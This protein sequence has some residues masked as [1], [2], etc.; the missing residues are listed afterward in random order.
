MITPCM[1]TLMDLLSEV[2]R[3]VRLTG[4]IHLRG[5]FTEPWAFLSTPP[6]LLAARYNLPEGEVTQFDV[7]VEG[8]CWVSAGKLAPVRMETGDVVIFPRAEQYIM[9]SDM[10]VTPVPI[11]DIFAQPSR[12]QITDLKY[13][14]PGRSARF[15]C[16]YLHFD[17]QFDPLLDSLPAL[18]CVRSRAG[19]VIFET[20]DKAGRWQHPLEHRQEAEWWQASLRYL[21]SETSAVGPG[22]RAV[23][24]RLAKSLFVQVLHWQLRYATQGRVGWLAGVHDPQIGRVLRLLHALPER[25]WTVDELAKEAA[26][27]RAALAKRFVELVGQSPIQYLANWRMHLA[28]QMLRES[29]LGIGE[30]AGRVGYRIRSGVQSCI[31]PPRR[32]TA[33]FVATCRECSKA[34]PSPFGLKSSS[35]RLIWA[36][37]RAF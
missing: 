6:E 26:I 12:E 31:P 30:I 5:D 34:R 21:I 22:N 4:A 28:R 32:H 29:N 36:A 37:R 2:L 33:R 16:G 35:S 3:V 13:G 7:F 20:W 23:L 8:D 18:L 25:P 15:I 9:A 27:S 19:E 11:K 14:G 1:G 17:H 10:G 24:A